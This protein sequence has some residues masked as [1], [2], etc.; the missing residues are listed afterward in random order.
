MEKKR[1]TSESRTPKTQ[2]LQKI[3]GNSKLQIDEDS[4][5]RL[6]GSIVEKG[7]TDGPSSRPF[8]PI[9]VPKP[10]VL[11]FPLARHRSHGPHWGPTSTRMIVGD[12]DDNGMH[13]ENGEELVAAERLAALAGPVQ[14]KERK[15]LNLSQW[16][17]LV[18]SKDSLHSQRINDSSN[19]G[20]QLQ[21][22]DVEDIYPVDRSTAKQE[23]V[24]FGTVNDTIKSTSSDLV[25]PIRSSVVNE[26]FG[27][28]QATIL[29]IDAGF[30]KGDTPMFVQNQ[31]GEDTSKVDDAGNDQVNLS[32][33]SQI[34]NENLVRLQGMSANEIAE[35]QAEIMDKMD[36]ALV[37]VLK[38]RGT[39]KLK[40]KKNLFDA[41]MAPNDKLGNPTIDTQSN[42]E[43]SSHLRKTSSQSVTT[44]STKGDDRTPGIV[45]TE[46]REP[47][48]N[49]LWNT[50]SDRVEGIR[51]L[52]FSLDGNI[53]DSDFSL[54]PETNSASVQSTD[55]VSERD[56]LRTEGDPG[57]AGY[58]IKE[59][60]AL[61]RSVVPGQR[62]L[63]LNLL[64]TV[65]EKAINY[66]A[67][68]QVGL[69]LAK[70]S[71]S[72]DFSVDWAAVW[73]FALGP[74]PELVLSLRM[75]LD[76]NHNSVVLA[77]TR[78]IQCILSC[79]LNEHFFDFLESVDV[80]G[81]DV[82][83]APVFRSKPEI[84]VGF[85][86]AGFWKY[87][88]KTSN[89]FPFGE[90]SDEENEGKHTI[91]D[92]IVVAGQD[93]AAGLIRMGILP[94]IRYLLE[95]DPS[96]V[97][98]ERLISILIAIARHSPA[99]ANAIMECP[100]LI[101]VIVE[102]FTSMRNIEINLSK[103]KSVTL[104]KVLAK[105]D[106]RICKQF[107][108]KTVQIM[109]W[110]L[111]QPCQSLDQWVMSGKESCKLS[112]SL[113]VQQ[114]RLWRVCIQYG[115]C[116]SNFSN[117]FH[118]ICLWL[119][120]PTIR[121]LLDMQMLQEFTS[122]SKEAFLVIGALASRLPDFDWLVP[123]RDRGLEGDDDDNAAW[124][125]SYV[126][127]LV[128]QGL[129]WIMLKNDAQVSELFELGVR[130]KN[131]SSSRD[132]TM[133]SSLL[134]VYSAVL[135]MFS[136]I[137]K[138]LD[139]G[140]TSNCS[141]RPPW[142]PDFVPR[143]GLELI[144]NGFL[145]SLSCDDSINNGSGQLQGRSFLQEL[146]YLR[147]NS[148]SMN[149]LACV[150]CL[151]A[152]VKVVEILDRSIHLAKS[153]MPSPPSEGLDL[154]REGKILENGIIKVC[155]PEIRRPLEIFLDIVTSEWHYVQS[156]E[157]FG[158]G[159]PAPGVGVG[160]GVSGGGFWSANILLAQKDAH[161]LIDLINIA[162]I[163]LDKDPTAI[164]LRIN[165]A[166]GACLVSGPRDKAV[167]E[168]TLDFLFQV[169][170]LRHLSFC[171]QQFAATNWTNKF[172]LGEYSEGDF[173]LVSNALLS[174][175]KKQWLCVKAKA[176]IAD[177][178]K[179]NVNQAR[180]SNT[181]LKTIHEDIEL[182]E[183]SDTRNY[184]SLMAEWA[185]QRLPLPVNWFLS[186]ISTVGFAKLD[187]DEKSL[188]KVDLPE[189]SDDLCDIAKAGLFFILGLEAVANTQLTC[190][191]SPVK[192]VPLVWKCH[193]LSMIL[194]VGMGILEDDKS[195]ILYETLQ[196]IYAQQLDQAKLC[197]ASFEVGKEHNHE[198]A[199]RFQLEIHDSYPT[200]I[201][202]L[203]NHFGAVSYGDLLYGR[204]VAFYLHHR[205]EASVQLA[206]WNALSNARVLDL[207]PP[208]EK[209]LGSPD[210]YLE[211][212]EDNE[213]ILEAYVK[214]WTSGALDRAAVR[215]SV[216]FTLVLHHIS[217]FLFL[218]DSTDK[219]LLCKKLAKSLLRDY[220]RRHQHEGLMLDLIRY[221]R[222]S[223][224]PSMGREDSAA[225]KRF[226]VLTELC[227]GNASL[228]AEVEKLRSAFLKQT[229][230]P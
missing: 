23:S 64:A 148:N 170:V 40:K 70:A 217:S 173:L 47:K 50:W 150:S 33:E 121:K 97:L 115:F 31:T 93:F 186:T 225:E 198:F 78:V 46:N 30:R 62:S 175:F 229:V 176:K 216:A 171:I 210:G 92:D 39:E 12:A 13:D 167:V 165:A 223:S 2:P 128:D 88:A 114:L 52:R 191:S 3:I 158:R 110:H 190:I 211:P 98:E 80:S 26:D 205:V 149:S 220:S 207:L 226:C 222:S 44:I 112:T 27:Q 41:G 94:R 79:D 221:N 130:Y 184:D 91:Q 59:A 18:Q 206:A 224:S 22:S 60:V 154:S 199:L 129:N 77:C 11:P 1:N 174:H 125:W 99:G 89:L 71:N 213:G 209:C 68:D 144:R 109:T 153:R 132:K 9:P 166:L 8:A 227:E 169:P 15:G 95:T 86:H 45:H 124:S 83:T 219:D 123:D 156:I 5:S 76:D 84:G 29:G 28:D 106:R 126:G 14:R 214:S 101:Q 143:I 87:S 194:L 172:V 42:T 180:E 74:E 48:G 212:A 178:S 131:N 197:N 111:Y 146:C 16:R 57:A 202:T 32:L 107:I 215:K 58:T 104:V 160:W 135:Q 6:I 85:L 133:Y 137:L 105:S 181:C 141:A 72:K 182:N 189:E 230:L 187:S 185:H 134:W 139:P 65:L 161:F 20:A 155:L 145:G 201:E 157:T 192:S 61:S 69:D 164:S 228:V 100:R 120:P 168:K 66:V 25:S 54:L 90:T 113:M 34:H 103:I 24:Y 117:L 127:P 218:N 204:Q 188:S 21:P 67:Q 183:S 203:V 147:V 138:K 151:H 208:L 200:F 195:R 118:S 75:S 140:N 179:N 82:Y 37:E 19:A 53:V 51:N 152:L 49:F 56:F 73:A 142:L 122:I 162:D 96:P 193:S 116:V 119:N 36:P 10:T 55:N 35:A 38:R 63:A 136:T 43:V 177:G 159:G 163:A 108:S 17:E 4:A 196:D 81:M 7:V 102:R